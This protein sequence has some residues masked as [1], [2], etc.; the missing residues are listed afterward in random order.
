VGYKSSEKRS[1]IGGP[2]AT[3]SAFELSLPPEHLP[4][5]P[6]CPRNPL[7]PS[8]GAGICPFHGRRKSVGLKAIR[9]V[10]TGGT[11]VSGT[12]NTTG[13]S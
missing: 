4:S 11:S 5:S 8:G 13:A 7:H 10:N 1:N 6:L 9:R 12:T 3:V 2:L